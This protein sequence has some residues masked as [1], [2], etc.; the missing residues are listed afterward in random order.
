[1]LLARIENDADRDAGGAQQ[2]DIYAFEVLRGRV[3]D[4]D[5]R[6]SGLQ[7]KEGAGTISEKCCTTTE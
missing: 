2:G 5:I 3:M 4:L 6:S 7:R 1:M